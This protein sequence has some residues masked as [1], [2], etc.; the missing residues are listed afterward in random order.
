M[1]K[2]KI[3]IYSVKTTADIFVSQK[4]EPV[5]FYSCPQAKL[6][7]GRREL[8]IPQK[9]HFLKIFLPELKEGER[10]M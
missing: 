3:Q 5:Q 1:V 2:E 8:S 7:P 4:I 9:Q 10:I 6:L